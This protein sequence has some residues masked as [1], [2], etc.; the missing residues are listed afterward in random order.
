[1]TGT[2]LVLALALAGGLGAGTRFVLD[3]VVGRSVS[4][5]FPLGTVLIN[6]SGSFLLGIVA[7]LAVTGAVPQPVALVA[8]TGFLGGYTTFSTASVEAV[9]LVRSGRL[10]LALVRASAPCPLPSVRRPS[11]S[12]SRARA[13]AAACRRLRGAE[14]AAHHPLGRACGG[15]LHIR[16]KGVLVRD[17]AKASPVPKLQLI[18]LWGGLAGVCCTFGAGVPP[19]SPPALATNR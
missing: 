17:A 10:P 7:G 8:G 16:H 4:T 11:A 2:V 19:A 9:R 15:V 13:E 3:G 18:T 6:I 12:G 14:V 5:A 1:V